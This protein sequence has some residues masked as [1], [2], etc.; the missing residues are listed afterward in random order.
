M[1][2]FL[3]QFASD[4][5]D[6]PEQGFPLKPE[7]WALCTIEAAEVESNTYATPPY[8]R[9]SGKLRIVESGS[10]E[11]DRKAKGVEFFRISYPPKTHPDFIQGPTYGPKHPKAGQT[12]PD[13]GKPNARWGREVGQYKKALAAV[14]APNVTGATVKARDEAADAM[15]LDELRQMGVTNLDG[16]A[17]ALLGKQVIVR[18]SVNAGLDKNGNLVSEKR[19]ADPKNEIANWIPATEANIAKFVRLSATPLADIKF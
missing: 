19:K 9:L 3:E 5:K 6:V 18:F 14:L 15:V 7:V 2:D 12:N 17:D 10:D 8:D 11:Q 13:A 4:L 1:S 16:V